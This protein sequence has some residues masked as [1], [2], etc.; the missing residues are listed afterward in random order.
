MK[1][2]L[3]YLIFQSLLI[4]TSCNP[5]DGNTEVDANFSVDPDTFS[6]DITKPIIIGVTTS[7]ANN[8]NPNVWGT[9]EFRNQV[10][11]FTDSECSS[12]VG[13]GNANDL[14]IYSVTV[15][16]SDNTTYDFWAQSIAPWGE[17]S[18]CSDMSVEFIEDSS[19]P[20]LPTVTGISP[21][22]PASVIN[23]TISGSADGS[24]IVQVFSNSLCTTLVTTGTADGSGDFSIS[25]S[26]AI[27][28]NNYWLNSKDSANNSSSCTSASTDYT[29]YS[30]PTGAAW[31]TGTQT[32][33][34]TTPHFINKAIA[35]EMEWSNSYVDFDYY[36]HSQTGAKEEIIVK[37]AGN[38]ALYLTIPMEF[39]AGTER[40]TVRAEVHVNGTLVDGGIGE[41][42]YIRNLGQ[43]LES[44]DHINIL[45]SNLSVGDIIEVTV[46]E[47]AGEDGTERV[48]VSDLAS[49]YIEYM[50]AAKTVFSATATETVSSTDLN[51]ITPSSLRWTEV[52]KTTGF[53]H[54]NVTS[55]ERI[56]VDT[57]GSYLVY[58]NIPLYSPWERVSVKAS[59]NVENITINNGYAMQGYIRS[60]SNHNNSSIHW[61]G[62]A[63]NLNA[64]NAITIKTEAQ[65]TAFTTTVGGEYASIFIE[66]IDITSNAFY[67]SGTSLTGGDNWNPA[68]SESINWDSVD[69][70]DTNIYNHSL[71]ASPHQITVNES[72]DYL[73]IYNDSVTSG[74]AR[75]NP[76]IS[77]EVNGAPV[78]G[79]ETK[80]HYIRVGTNHLESSA[81]LVFLLKN[82]SSGDVITLNAI[83][84][85]ITGVVDDLN[86]ATLFL[87]KK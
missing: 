15:T 59:I 8:N 24:S 68:I 18:D 30:I 72:G 32:T 43:H 53:T 1:Y 40:S 25:M 75:I 70:I 38:Y 62:L 52:V 3:L 39:T 83:Q 28:S 47:S 11:I 77:V 17:I 29:L 84:D 58:L 14:G 19:S 76:I 55:P 33:A 78:L 57:A 36:T 4:L 49:M 73:L 87:Y 42:S 6:G 20:S 51:L 23:P 81:I 5:F 22:S 35:Y 86:N 10:N 26:P 44:S 69:V 56:E 9:T 50:G 27:G 13:S 82:L 2:F 34:T 41:S 21:T 67:A 54:S 74:F 66:K 37:Q 65:S 48:I 46:N 71:V 60:Y 63:H 85:V 79:A 80:T 31:L 7:P 61:A 16:I 12:S 64:G 45:L